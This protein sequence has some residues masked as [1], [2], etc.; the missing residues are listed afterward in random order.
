[1]HAAYTFADIVAVAMQSF[2]QNGTDE[3][4]SGSFQEDR[5][6]TDTAV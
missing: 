1:M 4:G 5:P 6:I 2:L 3:L